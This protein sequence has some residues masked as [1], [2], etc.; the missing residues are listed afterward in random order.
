MTPSGAEDRMGRVGLV[1]SGMR[2]KVWTWASPWDWGTCGFGPLFKWEE[3]P[4]LG[5]LQ[6]LVTRHGLGPLL[7]L[8][9]RRGLG[10]LLKREM[11]F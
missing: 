9:W 7:E 1:P 10:P 8:D 3:R 11:R 6:E 4:R 2:E 5:S